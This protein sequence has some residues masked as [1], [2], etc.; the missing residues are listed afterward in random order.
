M[1][2]DESSKEGRQK[3]WKFMFPNKLLLLSLTLYNIMI[4][5]YL[6]ALG[7][8]C[9]IPKVLFSVSRHTAK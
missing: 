7:S 5:H 6:A 3:K 4:S 9:Q 2:V 1:F 8:V